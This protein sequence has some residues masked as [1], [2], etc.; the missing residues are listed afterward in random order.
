MR[1]NEITGLP[2]KSQND[3][4]RLT[5]TLQ[6]RQM[7]KILDLADVVPSKKDPRYVTVK[8]KPSAKS[9]LKQK[10]VYIWMH[11]DFGIFYVGIASRDNLNQRWGS[12]LFKLLG[13]APD[14]YVAAGFYTKQ[15]REFAEKFLDQGFSKMDV[16][17]VSK[18]LE[19]VRVAFYP[20]TMP[21]NLSP[22]EYKKGLEDLED[23]IVQR[24]NPRAQGK[25][26]ADKPTVSRNI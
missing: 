12:H 26:K 16:N 4:A 2:V 15:W 18:D 22:E 11:P 23:R 7:H 6:S 1:I 9:I 3:R 10:G 14:W 24:W 17:S 21:E 5:P 25:Y 19:K 20:I 8:W 13:R